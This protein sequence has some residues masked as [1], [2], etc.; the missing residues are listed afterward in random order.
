MVEPTLIATRI[1]VTCL[2]ALGVWVASQE[3]MALH[4]LRKL[5]RWTQ[6]KNTTLCARC[7][8]SFWGTGALYAL[9][10][11]PLYWEALTLPVYWLAAVGLQE[12]IDR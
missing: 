7:M 3:G 6:W 5:P 11:G 4:F 2:V 12:A 9:S 1:A 8:V 10:I